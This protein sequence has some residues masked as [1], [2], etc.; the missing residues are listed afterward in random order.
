MTLSE[1]NPMVTEPVVPVNG[2]GG[3]IVGSSSPS[4]ASLSV[5][6]EQ[7][8]FG[9]KLVA[10][11]MMLE[12]PYREM[13]EELVAHAKVGA[14][15]T[16][17]SD[18]QG[19]AAGTQWKL[20]R[21]ADGAVFD[22]PFGGPALTVQGGVRTPEER[23]AHKEKQHNKLRPMLKKVL[24]DVGKQMWGSSFFGKRYQVRDLEWPLGTWI[25]HSKKEI[26]RHTRL[27]T[28]SVVTAKGLEYARVEVLWDLSGNALGFRVND[29]EATD[30]CSESALRAVLARVLPEHV[31]IGYPLGK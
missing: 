5:T 1:T 15:V 25:V 11:G 8:E 27:K 2:S 24:D 4:E 29:I 16:A 18:V 14:A 31:L 3:A 9:L 12:S 10:F 17:E 26:V 28:G 22:N 23:E 13:L 19:F 20:P 7:Q 6:A 30:D 21:G